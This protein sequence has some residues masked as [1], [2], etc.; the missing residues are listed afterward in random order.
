MSR[1]STHKGT[2]IS[3]IRQKLRFFLRKRD[4]IHLVLVVCAISEINLEDTWK[5]QAALLGGDKPPSV[6]TDAIFASAL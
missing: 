4:F 2:I 5:L 6:A 1:Y 3:P